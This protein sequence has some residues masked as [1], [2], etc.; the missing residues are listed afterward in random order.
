MKRH[1]LGPALA[2]L[3]AFILGFLYWGPVTLLPYKA[4][5]PV[6]DPD[7]TAVAIG[8]L[9]PASGA[10][11]IPSPTLG[12]EKV[13]ALSER[14]PSVE[15]HIRQEPFTDADM[16]KCMAFGYLHMFVV[17][18][19]LSFML[20]GLAKS[21]ERWTCRVK[22]CAGIGLLVATGDLGYA[23]WWHHS[24]AWTLMQSIYDFLMYLT[25]GLVLAK[26]VTP[27]PAPNAP[28]PAA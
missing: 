17:S 1:V 11:L 12:A 27:K 25:I 16:G 21:F 19:L 9:F 26:F 2:A 28:A 18:V 20:C 3:A 7:G 5:G 23:I 15:V 13:K 10:Y 22:F 8:K 4:L 24:L 6:A 14:G